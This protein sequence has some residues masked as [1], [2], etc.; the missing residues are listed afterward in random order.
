MTKLIKSFLN[1]VDNPRS[2]PNFLGIYL[3]LW[4][5]WHHQ[6]L[7]SFGLATGSVNNRLDKAMAIIGEFQYLSVFF[8][9]ITLFLCYFAFQVFVN[10]AREHVDK[11]DLEDNHHLSDLDK[12]K[13]MAQ[14]VSTLEALQK[15]VKA[16]EENEKKAKTEAKAVM[17]K[18]MLVQT[19][20]DETTAD[21]DILKS[22]QH[23]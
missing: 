23:K 17:A 3:L 15:Q 4:L 7:L 1:I 13:D 8:A 16:A 11:K 10:S 19:R 9:T 5:I 18:L 21:L 2:L 6:F 12:Q 22:E 20:L 14:L